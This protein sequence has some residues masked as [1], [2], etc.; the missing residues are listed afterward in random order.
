MQSQEESFLQAIRTA[1]GDETPRLV[2][3]DWLEEAGDERAPWV[4][5]AKLFAWMGPNLENPIPKL[6]ASLQD[7]LAHQYDDPN[8]DPGEAA[9][10]CDLLVRSGGPA[11]PPLLEN[12]ERGTLPAEEVRG[13]IRQLDHELPPFVG[14]LIRLAKSDSWDVRRTAIEALVVAAG[15][16]E[17]AAQWVLKNAQ[18]PSPH[19]QA[20]II[21]GLHV[22]TPKSAQ[23]LTPPLLAILEEGIASESDDIERL[24]MVT[25]ALGALAPHSV[26]AVPVL[27]KALHHRDN[28]ITS[29]ASRALARFGSDAQSVLIEAL[30][31]CTA[32]NAEY[33]I[34]LATSITPDYE[35]YLV[36][37]YASPTISIAARCGIV[38]ALATTRE[39]KIPRVL[40][41]FRR[42][43]R[44]KDVRLG[45]AAAETLGNMRWARRDAIDL[46]RDAFRDDSYRIRCA[47]VKAVDRLYDSDESDRAMSALLAGLCDEHTEVRSAAYDALELRDQLK[48]AADALVKRFDEKDPQRFAGAVTGIGEFAARHSEMCEP[49]LQILNMP[50]LVVRRAAAQALAQSMD[51]TV[52]G[53]MRPLLKSLR[54]RDDVVSQGAA[55]ALGRIGGRAADAIPELLDMTRDP[56]A[57]VRAG[58]MTALGQIDPENPQ[59]VK[60]LRRTLHGDDERMIEATLDAFK[61][62]FSTPVEMLFAIAELANHP[63]TAIRLGV[64]RAM[65]YLDEK[66]LVPETRAAICRGLR[67]KNMEVAKAANDAV[68]YLAEKAAF[69]VDDLLRLVDAADCPFRNEVGYV[70][71][72]IVEA[73]PGLTQRL[74][75]PLRSTRETALYALASMARDL[76]A[77]KDRIGPAVVPALVVILGSDKPAI[78]ELALRLAAAVGPHAAPCFPKILELIAPDRHV[79]RDDAIF[80]LGKLGAAALP[81]VARL[82]D[83]IASDNENERPAAAEAL[84]RLCPFQEDLVTESIGLLR[85]NNSSIRNRVAQVFKELPQLAAQLVGPLVRCISEDED[86]DVRRVAAESLG[87]MGEQVRAHVPTICTVLHNEENWYTR[88]YIIEALGKLGEAAVAAEDE[89]LH[90]LAVEPEQQVRRYAIDAI[91]YI[92]SKRRTQVLGR[93]LK[94]VDSSVREGAAI[95]L[96]KIGLDALDVLPQIC[97]AIADPKW[98]DGDDYLHQMGLDHRCELLEVLKKLGPAAKDAI[99]TLRKTLDDRKDFVRIE[100]AN[101]LVAIGPEAEWVLR[102]ALKHRDKVVSQI[103]EEALG[104]MA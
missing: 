61:D 99:P 33:V 77:A 65:H 43:L 32:A 10:L 36:N 91:A 102:K 38:N 103:A 54:D 28:V 90:A 39:E 56:S 101:A 7:A 57:R 97:E 19:L 2:Y 8:R 66:T 4:R 21:N 69:A 70:L 25:D 100:T 47:S 72:K 96:Q 35:D 86:T 64:A 73:I 3:A 18:N 22:A 88:Q 104:K 76:P 89:L 23:L 74:N 51:H 30:C 13:I 37:L 44:E 17:D 78:V 20:E 31:V 49:I 94:D 27:G 68:S 85:A 42:A 53:A 29:S 63:R 95:G 60:V 50:F 87:A 82:R 6:I 55:L 41:I 52:N 11:I 81:A 40:P 98:D 59:V 48:A 79:A 9:M 24:Q 34:G 1:P 15:H 83:I 45:V 26:A 71:A 92:P 16:E 80:T 5:D 12:V 58:A 67:D 14:E 93:A 75:N 84:A 62:R 46:L